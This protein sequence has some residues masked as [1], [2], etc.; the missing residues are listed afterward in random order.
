MESGAMASGGVG[1]FIRHGVEGYLVD[2]D[3]EMGETTAALLTDVAHLA[4]IQQH[5]RDTV[6]AMTWEHVIPQH[7]TTYQTQVSLSA[8]TLTSAS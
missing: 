5:N 8:L 2:S 1:E 4:W 7:L 3:V 6:P